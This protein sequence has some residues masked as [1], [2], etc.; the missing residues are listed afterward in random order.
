MLLQ[1]SLVKFLLMKRAL[2]LIVLLA[3]ATLISYLLLSKK[4]APAPEKKP[5][6]FSVTGKSTS[7]NIAFTSMLD[8]YY[9]LASSFVEWDTAAIRAASGQLSEKMNGLRFGELKTDSSVIQTAGSLAQ[10]VT[11][12]LSG[13]NGESTIDQKRRSFNMVTDEIYNLIRTVHYDGAI[14]YHMKCPMAFGDSAEGFWLSRTQE[15][16]NPYLGNKHPSFKNKMVGCGEVI[17]SIKYAN[18]N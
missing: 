11:A 7:F 13:L 5:E 9:Q 8:A 4:N 3:V 6:A 17:D 18:T 12:E 2:L 10:S 16:V 15:I 14:V 1:L